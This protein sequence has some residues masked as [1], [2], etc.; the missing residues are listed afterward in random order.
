MRGASS[1]RRRWRGAGGEEESAGRPLRGRGGGNDMSA[2]AV[3]VHG[4]AA[5][6]P[7]AFPASLAQPRFLPVDLVRGLV[8]VVMAIDHVRD[9]L[10]AARFN[11]TDLTRTTP[12]LF[13]TRWITHLC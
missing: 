11:P 5:G 7:P 3:V 10:G 13:F 4:E 1:R 6:A 9:M 12:A 8:M 2:E